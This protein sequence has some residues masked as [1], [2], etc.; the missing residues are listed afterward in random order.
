MRW[1]PVAIVAL[2]TLACSG[3][4]GGTTPREGRA[5]KPPATSSPDLKPARALKA[6]CFGQPGK[7]WSTSNHATD[8]A[9]VERGD[10]MWDFTLEDL[11]GADHTLSDML[12]TAPVLLV[13]GSYSCPVYRKNRPKVDR[14]AKKYGKR[15]H[16]VVL[17]GP[18]A[19][20]ESDPSP[21]RGTPWPTD[22]FSHVELATSFAERKANAEE[23][24]RS[25]GV[26]V[27]VEPLDNPVWCSI[28]TT[29]NGAWLVR[30][31]G[32]FEAVHD[33]FDGASMVESIDA[34]LGR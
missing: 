31:D 22:K 30:Q 27:L 6:G 17:H 11:D 4:E 33:W 14:I 18:E 21:Y 9:F 13:T 16:V 5:E 25:P 3:G 12:A 10:R 7:A 28:G 26:T 24:G 20:P 8:E 29:P 19:H 1:I 34:L 15:L 32:T 2:T 23:V